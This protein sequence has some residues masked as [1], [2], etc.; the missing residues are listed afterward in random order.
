MVFWILTVI[1]NM[2]G[3]QEENTGYVIAYIC[4]VVGDSIIKRGLW[5]HYLIYPS[6]IFVLVWSQD[7]CFY[8]QMSYCFM[9]SL[10]VPKG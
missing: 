3:Y 4:I 7:M 1:S 2:W 6:H 9:K 10:K 5:S 8:W